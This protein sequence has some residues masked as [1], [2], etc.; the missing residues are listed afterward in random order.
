M[1]TIYYERDGISNIL[2]FDATM[3]ETLSGD[4]QVSEHPVEEGADRA[5]HFRAKRASITV[6]AMVTNTPIRSSGRLVA[7][8]APLVLETLP[9]VVQDGGG[10]SEGSY[11]RISG[12]FTSPYRPPGFPRPHTPVSVTPGAL[13]RQPPPRI[14]AEVRQFLNPQDRLLDMWKALDELRLDGT[15]C[16]VFAQVAEFADMV[17]TG[18]SLPVESASSATFDIT[19]SPFDGFSSLT[20]GEVS[21]IARTKVKSAEAEK[22]QG[23]K[24]LRT[25]QQERKRDLVSRGAKGLVDLFSEPPTLATV[26]PAP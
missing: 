14:V 12:G 17:I 24:P 5:D 11:P 9:A 21:Q 18:L 19:F 16:T 22:A 20:F 6:S 7:S 26:T 8:W 23:P 4:G 2:T 13:T 10:F 15:T 1:A 25:V 3:R